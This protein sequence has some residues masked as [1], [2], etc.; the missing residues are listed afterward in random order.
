MM[1]M[2]IREVEEYRSA[3]DDLLAF[4]RKEGLA[5]TVK[6]LNEKYGYTS[7]SREVYQ[8]LRS[9]KND[10]LVARKKVR[11]SFYWYAVD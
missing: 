2:K 8:L 6:E 5:F 4:L 9:L 1:P 7:K 11:S 10:N 3:Q